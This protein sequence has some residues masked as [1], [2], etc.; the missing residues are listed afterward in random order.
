M[1]LSSGL[2][3][4]YRLFKAASGMQHASTILSLLQLACTILATHQIQ[5]LAILK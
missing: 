2:F 5:M 3:T 4:F 1:R